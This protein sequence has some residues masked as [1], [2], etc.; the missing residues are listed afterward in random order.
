[1]KINSSSAIIIRSEDDKVFVTKR[2][3]DKKYSPGKWETVGGRVRSKETNEEGLKR[4]VKEEINV[5][6]KSFEFFGDYYY[7]DR[8]F[9]TFIV[10]LDGEPS[11]NKKDFD[12][13]GWFGKNEIEKMNFAA[14]CKDRILDYFNTQGE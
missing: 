9:K 11:P 5:G 14:N 12:D 10:E 13:W 3:L 2:S 7:D 8:T 1:M 4:E 6:I